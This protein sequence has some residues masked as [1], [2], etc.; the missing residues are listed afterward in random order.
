MLA[1]DFTKAELSSD[2]DGYC[3]A[4]AILRDNLPGRLVSVLSVFL[5]SEAGAH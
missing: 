4:P 3:L 2:N 5:N 1:E